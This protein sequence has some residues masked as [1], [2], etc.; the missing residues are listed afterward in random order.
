MANSIIPKSLSADLNALYSKVDG[1]RTIGIQSG[2]KIRVSTSNIDTFWFPFV[3]IIGDNMAYCFFRG[4]GTPSAIAV[5]GDAAAIQTIKDNIVAD[6]SGA[7]IT[8]PFNGQRGA[9]IL[10]APVWVLDMLS[11][12]RI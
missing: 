1:I 3:Y 10:C 12:S 11:I 4:S 8:I 2:Y 5:V 6:S 9:I 7:T